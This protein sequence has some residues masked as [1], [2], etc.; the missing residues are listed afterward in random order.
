M[1]ISEKMKLQRW[2][3]EVADQANSGLGRKA[4]CR[5]N[6]IPLS[7]FRY[8]KRRVL[9]A[10]EAELTPQPNRIAPTAPNEITFTQVPDGIEDSATDVCRIGLRSG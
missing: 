10:A 8:H 3:Q 2:A 5:L 7:T 9:A 1:K 4:W 6:G